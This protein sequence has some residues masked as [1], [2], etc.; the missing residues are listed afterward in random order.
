MKKNFYPKQTFPVLSQSTLIMWAIGGKT[1]CHIK[2]NKTC[3]IFGD[4]VLKN[5]FVVLID[6]NKIFVRR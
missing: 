3:Q 5:M 1:F 2:T 4:S 6:T